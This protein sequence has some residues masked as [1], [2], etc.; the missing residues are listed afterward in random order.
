MPWPG[1]SLNPSELGQH[2]SLLMLI[3]AFAVGIADLAGLIALEE[4]NLAESFVGVHLGREGSGVGDF[5]GDET[6]PLGL[7]GSHVHDD[8]AAGVGGFSD[9]DGED[10]A[11]NTEVLDG[12]GQREGVW[13]HDDGRGLNGYEGPLVKGLGVNDGAIDIGEDFELVGNAEVVAL[14]REAIGNDAFADLFF[15]E[16]LDHP[17]VDGLLPDP[18]VTLNRHT[19]PGPGATFLPGRNSMQMGKFAPPSVRKASANDNGGCGIPE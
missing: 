5:E 2:D 15:A 16:R 18:T 6:L 4:E 14:G 3:L 12:A 1:W 11:G 17:V 9:A 7:E 8:S 13:R 19:T 10:I